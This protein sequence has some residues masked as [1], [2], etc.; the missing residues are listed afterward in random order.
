MNVLTPNKALH[1]WQWWLSHHAWK[2]ILDN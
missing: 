2:E 1:A